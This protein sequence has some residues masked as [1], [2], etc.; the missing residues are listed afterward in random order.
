MSNDSLSPAETLALRRKALLVQCRMQRLMLKAEVHTLIAPMA[1]SQGWRAM[2]PRLK[3]PLAVGGLVLSL[4]AAKPSR[5]MPIMQIGATLLAVFK[6]VLPLLRRD[7]A[8][9]VDADPD[10]G[11]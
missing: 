3:V 5:A 4:I 9:Q 1:P 7:R 11:D 2:L 8:G 10:S 6:T